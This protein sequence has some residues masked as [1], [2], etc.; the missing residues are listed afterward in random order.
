MSAYIQRETRNTRQGA[1]CGP[2]RRSKRMRPDPTHD[3]ARRPRWG[4]A[5]RCLKCCHRNW[6]AEDG[7]SLMET[8]VERPREVELDRA[9]DQFVPE[10]RC[11]AEVTQQQVEIGQ[12]A[13]PMAPFLVVEKMCHAVQH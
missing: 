12:V 11:R 10:P 8:V 6:R 4:G 7:V 3:R 2:M 13:K 5:A 1:R 9:C